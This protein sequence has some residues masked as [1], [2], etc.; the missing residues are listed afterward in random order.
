MN[1]LSDFFVAQLL[2]VCVYL[3]L[4]CFSP[5]FLPKVEK[6]DEIKPIKSR[7]DG[8]IPFD[9]LLYQKFNIKNKHLLE[10]LCSG[11][12]TP[13]TR[14]TDECIDALVRSSVLISL[15]AKWETFRSQWKRTEKHTQRRE[16]LRLFTFRV[17]QYMAFSRSLPIQNAIDRVCN[18][19]SNC[20]I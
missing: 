20:T 15:L 17:Y 8:W 9:W 10:K 1:F 7:I 2:K 6:G 11:I 19:P 4:Q 16:E 5:L 3:C 12:G 18:E 13:R 14:A